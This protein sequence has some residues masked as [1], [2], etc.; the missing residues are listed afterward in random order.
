M[1]AVCCP[2]LVWVPI[3]LRRHVFTPETSPKKLAGWWHIPRISWSLNTLGRQVA[4][5]ACTANTVTPESKE[6]PVE[7]V[8]TVTVANNLEP[9]RFGKAH[10]LRARVG[11]GRIEFCSTSAVPVYS[12]SPS[13]TDASATVRNVNPVCPAVNHDKT[14]WILQTDVKP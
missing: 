8:R 13:S 9:P 5:A 14:L 3:A 1:H 12:S 4:R 2:V 11:S 6:L 10:K 7:T